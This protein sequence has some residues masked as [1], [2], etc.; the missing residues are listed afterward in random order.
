MDSSENP[1]SGGFVPRGAVAFFISLI[2]IYGLMWFSLYFQ[3]L[4]RF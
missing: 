2:L 4:G 1:H 3:I